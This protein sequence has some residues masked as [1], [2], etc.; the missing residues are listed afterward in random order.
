MGEIGDLLGGGKAVQKLIETFSSAVGKIYEP[1]HVR[2]M[3]KAEA[4]RRM[5]LAQADQKVTELHVRASI[6]FVEQEQRRQRN[7]DAIANYAAKQ[8]A[9]DQ[10]SAND[11]PVE[12]DWM[13]EFL[14]QSQDISNEQ[15]QALWGRI[16]ASE[17]RRPGFFSPR[18]L[19]LTKVLSRRE[20]E[21]FTKLA[22]TA[23]DLASGPWLAIP[24]NNGGDGNVARVLAA[25]E[26]TQSTL[27]QLQATGLITVTS[28]ATPISLQMTGTVQFSYQG[29]GVVVMHENPQA[30]LSIL[31]TVAS[32]TPSGAELLRVIERSP[33]DDYVD[34]MM[35]MWK[36]RKLTVRWLA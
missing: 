20:A 34:A 13:A 17:V 8:L 11:E 22:N 36:T 18:T 31:T 26:I 12:P 23:W 27:R 28:G 21:L 30:R 29:R 2:R 33:D 10:E 25:R 24:L 7:I 1:T 6:R 9:R 16:L 5:I 15:M 19:Q 35:K 14:S 3:A 32:L 4:E